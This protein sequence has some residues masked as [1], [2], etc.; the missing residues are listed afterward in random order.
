MVVI[1]LF[2]LWKNVSLPGCWHGGRHKKG[3]ALG[4][5]LGVTE[6]KV[7]CERRMTSL[8]MRQSHPNQPMQGPHSSLLDFSSRSWGKD[9]HANS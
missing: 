1:T 8:G 4:T 6:S 2:D 7:A 9:V 5:F 3:S